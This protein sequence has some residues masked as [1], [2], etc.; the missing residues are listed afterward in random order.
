MDK[1]YILAVDQG[2]SGTKVAII[3]SKGDII[4][5][6]SK[7]HKQYYPFPGWIEHNPIE[8]Y[9]N[10]KLLL[11]E[12]V[13]IFNL[14][15]E[16][17]NVLSIT[18][19]RDTIVVWD[20]Q[21]GKPLYNAIVW[22][23]RRTS[24]TCAKLKKMGFE[25][26]IKDKTGLMLDPCYSATKI[27]WILDNVEG[28]RQ[29]AKAGK[30]LAGTIDAWLI[31]KLTKGKIHATDYTNANNTLLFNI[32]LLSWDEELLE[33]FDI[34][35]NILPEVKSSNYI[36]GTTY[37]GELFNSEIPISGIIGDSQGALFGE[38][39]FEPGMVKATYG[40]G[41]SI[42]MNTGDKL[43]QSKRGLVT[44][45]A[46]RVDDKV[47]YALEGDITCAGDA[48][49]WVKDNLGLFKE[50]SEVESLVKSLKDN[51]GV[52]M[53]PAFSG[54]GAPHWD[55][56]AR[57]AIVGLS[58]R[59]KIEH[60][61]RAALESTAYQVKDVVEIMGIE[62]GIELKG[63][64]INGGLTRNNFLVQFQSDMLNI[65]VKKSFFEDVSLIGSAYL[66]G[67]GIGLW[68][69]IED[70]KELRG[71]SQSYNPNMDSSAREK[72]YKGWKSA[73][74]KVLTNNIAL[75]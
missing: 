17:V 26:T 7:E 28:A 60:I 27:K 53:V 11:K 24:D 2:T 9:E 40:T 4:A 75:N 21:T 55:A 15:P 54:L 29:K 37:K 8:I 44:V 14:N 35:Q 38:Q 69:G 30:I 23:C 68:G 32:R 1:G 47:E 18:N 57:A 49:K 42:M 62:S 31:W 36:F 70:I 50:Y 3:S 20:K 19:Q 52:Y 64:R 65:F 51:E 22:Q 5:S 59:S 48:L 74:N 33:I 63:L 13:Q 10:V 41:S 39:C 72:Y 73:V 12:V 16:N 25:K 34:P 6:K 56:Y 66:A 58:R 43:I 67:L 61:V 46:W 71:K 45:I